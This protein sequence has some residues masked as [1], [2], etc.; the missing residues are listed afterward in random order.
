M[1]RPLRLEHPGAIWHV[2]AR[3]NRREAI[4]LDDDDRRRFVGRLADTVTLH[5]WRLH[6]WVLMTN[7]YHLLLETP[8]PNLSRGMQ[9]LNA[10][11]SQAFN[12]R[13]GRVGHVLQGRYKSILVERE[14]HLL[15]LTRYV[16]L[17]PVRA[18]MTPA[19]G[20]F[21]WSSY[22]ETA[23]DRPP[24]CWLETSWT[25]RQFGGRLD[26]A[27]RRYREFVA[28]G[29][30]GAYRPWEQLEG[31][32]YLGG[33]EFRR[34]AAALVEGARPSLEVPLSQQAPVARPT[35]ERTLAAV[36]EAFHTTP[37]AIRAARRGA[38]RKAVALLGRRLADARLV[39]VGS[40]LGV[41]HWSA[42]RLTARGKAL[43]AA[44]ASFRRRLDAVSRLLTESAKGQT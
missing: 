4:V 41:R 38:A 29:V 8:E 20:A 5:R 23:G 6:A 32:I 37:A 44:D 14:T 16:V 28:E 26:T 35:L 39:D 19:P 18:G 12:A 22:G 24:A 2:T 7:H 17:N 13:H 43:E 33:E 36:A 34:R 1:A 42:S 3:G 25:L 30:A 21:P 9:R 11:Y 31:Q 15:E 27:R 40:A 10:P